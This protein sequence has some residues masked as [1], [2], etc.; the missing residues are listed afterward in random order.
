MR[1]GPIL[2]LILSATL[3][4]GPG[5]PAR[6]AAAGENAK[7]WQA[8]SFDFQ[9][10]TASETDDNPNPFLDFRLQVEF[11]A[12]S[13]RRYDVPGFFDGDGAGAGRGNVWRVRFTPDEPGTWRYQASFRKGP[14]VAVSLDADAGE[15]AQ[16]NGGSGRF[17]VAER[18]PEAPGFL[19]WGRLEYV[20]GHYLKFKDGPYWIRGGT[21][22]PENFLAYKGFDNT[23]GSHAYA[24]HVA[25]WRPGDPDWGNERGKAIIG[26][27]NSLASQHVNSVYFLTMNIGGD[28]QDVW[29]WAGTPKPNG[30]PADDNLHFDLSKLRQWEMVFDHAQK[31]GIFLHFVFNEAERPNKREL[32]NGELGDE[33]KLY[34]REIIARFGHHL[35]LEWNLCEEFNIGFNLGQDRVREFARYVGAVDP[36]DH[37]VTVHSAGDPIK[38]LQFTFGDPLFSLTSIQLNQRRIDRVTEAFRKATE[39]AGRPLPVSLDEFTVDVG[40]AASHVPADDPDKYRMEKIWP[41]YFSG[42]MIEFILEDLL[43]VESFKTEKKAALWAYLWNARKFMEENLPFWEMAPVD[44]LVSGAG[45]ITVGMGGGK[46]SE[47][48]AQVLAKPG[49]VYAIYL[50]KAS[51]A[52]T[53]DVSGYPGPYSV[54]WYNPRT[55]RFAGSAGL[56]SGAPRLPI[57][58]PPSDPDSDWVVLFKAVKK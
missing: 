58:A 14:K 7:V 40:Q 33:R 15:P 34:Y 23:T 30:S 29:P 26:V 46:T 11:T 3:T 41:T 52:G 20:G 45:T 18:D 54:R 56:V 51:P 8:A 36:Y 57:G 47:L 1:Y 35:A 17:A 55:G 32:D 12:P 6:A 24:D 16:I 38:M 37:P 5:L 39:E 19:K 28:G 53:L 22:S 44:N 48:G 31:K 2:S 9:G 25:D 10:P 49:E 42:G 43:K 13:G 50:P 21:D 27:L 4:M